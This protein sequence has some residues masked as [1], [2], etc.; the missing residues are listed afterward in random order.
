[1]M[2]PFQLPAPRRPVTSPAAG[3]THPSKE[4]SMGKGNNRDKREVKKPKKDKKK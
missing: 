2:I 1:M 4:I 3:T